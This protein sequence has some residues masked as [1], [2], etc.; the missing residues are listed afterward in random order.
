MDD[1]ARDEFRAEVRAFLAGVLPAGW[2]GAG[3]LGDDELKSFTTAFRARMHEARLLAVTWPVEYGGRGLTQHDQV[4]LAEEMVR[5]GLPDVG[6]WD[7]FG[8]KMLGNTLLRWGT[9]A[10]K[11][12]FLP[13]ILA[14]EDRW[15][16]GF[17]EPSAGSDL[18]NLAL[19]AER[20][21]DRWVI[22]GQ[23]LWTSLADH[24]DWIFLLA[25]TAPDAPKHRGITFLLC[26][27]H[28][29]GAE[30]RPIR[31]MG[32]HD[33]FCEVFFSDAETEADLVVGEVGGGWAVANTLLGFERGEAAATFAIKFREEL[34]RLVA[35]ARERDAARSARVRQRLARAYTEVEIMRW[36]GLRSLQPLLRGADPGPASSIAK[37]YWSE[38]HRRV[39]ELAIDVLGADALVPTGRWPRGAVRTDDPAS[40]NDSASWVGTFLNARAGTI[41]AGTSE[42]QR[43]ILGEQVLGLPRE[44]RADEGPW[45]AT[46]RQ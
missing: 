5:A 41:Y 37:L 38:Y 43:N 21:G 46:R 12:R 11:Q 1:A 4:T 13:R 36:L 26:P 32:G 15:C 6:V 22:N 35:L 19:R 30:A 44:P 28:Q 25:R 2:R 7:R 45:S 34:D 9:E 40:P 23:K 3:A 29:P 24:A 20:R 27:L 33:H 14:G 10:Q 39:T 31:T 42:V 8:I 18:A 17:S 16:Q